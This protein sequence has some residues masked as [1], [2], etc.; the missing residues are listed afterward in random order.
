MRL[1]LLEDETDL[2][3]ILVKGLHET[4]FSVDLVSRIDEAEDA[5]AVGSFDVAVLDR[6]VPDGDSLDLL[7]RRPVEGLGCPVLML[8]ARD[9][10][11]DRLDGLEAGADDYLLKPFHFDELV[12]RLRALLRRPNKA[13]GVRVVSGNISFDTPTRSAQVGG[14]PLALSRR[15]LALLELLMRRMGTVVTK[16]VIETTLYTFDD[17]VGQNAIEVLVHRLR[18]R[19]VT[20]GATPQ[21]HTLRGIGYMLENVE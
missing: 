18:R 14:E 10:L 20:A 2:A 9:A 19:L 11:Q 3:G 6:I 7:R 1:L 5:L 12:A 16:D 4:G 13:L 15:E 8:T 21:I 17:E